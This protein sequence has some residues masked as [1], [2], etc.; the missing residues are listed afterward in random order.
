ME[1]VGYDGRTLV[2]VG[3]AKWSTTAEDG[4]ALDQLRSSAVHVPGYDPS[5]TRLLLYTRD[6]VTPRFAERAT[7]QGVILRTV[8]DLY[9][10]VP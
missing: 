3:E 8:E 4:R 2:L 7:A 5:L 6:P 9:A 10:S 1:I